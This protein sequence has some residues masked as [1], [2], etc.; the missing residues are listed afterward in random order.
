MSKKLINYFINVPNK[1]PPLPTGV[2]SWHPTGIV[3][4]I[5]WHAFIDQ[6]EK[7]FGDLKQFTHMVHV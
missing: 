1:I 4:K 5:F 7:E 6:M 3:L 2:L